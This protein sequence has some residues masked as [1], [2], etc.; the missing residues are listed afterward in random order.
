M[1]ERVSPL[2]SHDLNDDTS[3]H[4]KQVISRDV[5]CYSHIY[6]IVKIYTAD[7][8]I[9][10]D[11]RFFL[12]WNEAIGEDEWMP[13]FGQHVVLKDVIEDVIITDESSISYSSKEKTYKTK[14]WKIIAKVSTKLDLHDF[15]FDIQVLYV[16]F[17]IPRVHTQNIKSVSNYDEEFE[18]NDTLGL[19]NTWNVKKVVSFV[20][21]TEPG[22]ENFKPE[23]IVKFQIQ[24]KGF[25]YVKNFC[26]PNFIF[27]VISFS[28]YLD[29]TSDIVG[30][31]SILLT[32]LL[33][34]VAFKFSTV[35]SIPQ[36]TYETALENYVLSLFLIISVS[37]IESMI[38][39]KL[40]SELSDLVD[41]IASICLGTIFIVIHIFWIIWC[42][43]KL[44]LKEME[45]RDRRGNMRN[46]NQH[47]VTNL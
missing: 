29:E 32:L 12:L 24:R 47:S 1:N 44:N 16:K 43:K 42:Y 40:R 21:I 46:D 27:A 6:N 45:S 23:Y 19:K 25:Y 41:M 34:V 35:S 26:F 4:P 30:R 39:C 11:L 8:Y 17:R 20:D 15:P 33:T 7:E 3:V 18:Y 9:T 36:L 31:L 37:C 10:I 38:V 2:H 5:L 28:V 13:V 14:N 22:S